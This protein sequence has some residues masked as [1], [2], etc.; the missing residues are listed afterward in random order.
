MIREVIIELKNIHKSFGN[1]EVLK[2]VSLKIFK[3]EIISIIGRSG[4]GKSVLLKHVNRL[5]EPDRGEIFFKGSNIASFNKKQLYELRKNTSFLFQ[6]G[7]LFDSMSVEENLLLPLIYHKSNLS[8]Q[9]ML[10]AVA[11]KLAMVGMPNINHLTTSELSGGMKKRV[12]L[13]RAIIMEPEIIMYDEPTTGLDP[14]MS[15]TINKLIVSL[16]K[17]LQITSIVI[18]HDLR[19]I[20]EISDRVAMIHEGKLVFLGTPEELKKSTN[21]VIYNFINGISN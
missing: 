8:N 9:E 4:I 11:E 6:S 10:R 2:G 7:A 18:T 1:K 3:G 12:G 14:I 15:D 19:T 20:L 13:A 16:N 5:L 21:Q 17:K